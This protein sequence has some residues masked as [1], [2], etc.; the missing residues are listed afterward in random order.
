LERDVDVNFSEAT[1]APLSVQDDAE[2]DTAHPE[3]PADGRGVKC[4]VREPEERSERRERESPW[5]G[6]GNEAERDHVPGMRHPN[7]SRY[8]VWREEILSDVYERDFTGSEL[9]RYWRLE[10]VDEGFVFKSAS[11]WL[12]DVGERVVARSGNDF[13]IRAM[14]ELV[15]IKGWEAVE[16]TGDDDF[17][18]RAITA[19]LRRG[20]A[21]EA[22]DID[23]E[24]LERCKTELA[25]E[26]PHVIS[27]L[28]HE[29]F[30]NRYVGIIEA[31][32]RSYVYQRVGDELIAH[33]REAFSEDRAEKFELAIGRPKEI[34]YDF[35]GPMVQPVIERELEIELG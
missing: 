17:K 35:D 5:H 10:R 12:I 6:R 7:R 34:I 11:G 26:K 25:A 29:T 21:V 15:S 3:A 30:G 2:V 23:V 32:D 20:I 18:Q 27:R 24:L 13:E 4:G 28:A 33:D 16:F 9:A 22:A 8:Q 14:L 31:V 19:A 1:R